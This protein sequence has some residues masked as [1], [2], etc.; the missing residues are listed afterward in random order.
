MVKYFRLDNGTE[1]GEVNHSESQWEM[2]ILRRCLLSNLLHTRSDWLYLT[3]FLK[4]HTGA[5]V[6]LVDFRQFF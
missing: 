4:F 2:I 6:L 5:V 3:L 1:N